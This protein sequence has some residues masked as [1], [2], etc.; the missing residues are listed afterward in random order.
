M[1]HLSNEHQDHPNQHENSH[2]QCDEAGHTAVNV[3]EGQWKQQHDRDFPMEGQPLQ[4]KYLCQKKESIS[5]G[6]W[7]SQSEIRVGKLTSD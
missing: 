4:N 2:T 7:E 3:M 5:A 1:E 6:L